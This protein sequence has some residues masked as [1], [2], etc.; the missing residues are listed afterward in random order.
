MCPQRSL[1]A[2]GLSVLHVV[3]P[4][5]GG[6]ARVVLDLVTAQVEQGF[7]VSLAC[8]AGT[9]LA[10]S[11]AGL[12]CE[13]LDWQSTRSPVRHVVRES[14]HLAELIARVRPDVVHAHSAKAGLV[15]RV[16]LRGRIPTVFQPHAWSFEA[17]DS[18]TSA[19]AL[20]WERWAAR[21]TTRVVCVSEAERLRG[22]QAGVRTRF[23]VVQNGV[24]PARFTFDT[25]PHAAR[26]ALPALAAGRSNESPVVVCVG[27]LCMQKGQDTLLQAWDSV[28]ARFPDARLALV[29]DGPT[30]DE[31]R[32]IAPP[33]VTFAGAVPDTAPWYRAAD[34]VVLPSRWEGI[35]VAPLE[36]MATGRAVVVTDV[37]G[38]R[39]SLP[40][41]H[42][43][44][45][46]VPPDDPAALASAVIRLLDQAELRT[47][48]GRQG[49]QHVLSH[50]TVQRVG[51]AIADV[52]REVAVGRH[53][54][55][56]EP[57]SP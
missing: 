44:L 15:A 20:R 33:S 50:F 26:R 1:D 36:A 32:R 4:G 8:P 18:R 19:L 53:H 45:S 5:E 55:F 27:R 23:S 41:A 49:R 16:V 3:Q 25:D 39:E 17:V 24:D 42:H 11:A 22:Q 46:L 9:P 47:S 54:K 29:G 7:T 28:V 10:E 43:P 34:L 57:V 6:V 56:R 31:L 13:L 30:G 2:T 37:D 35:A 40:P 14:R 48:L 52:Y 12:G 51:A 21:W 38:S